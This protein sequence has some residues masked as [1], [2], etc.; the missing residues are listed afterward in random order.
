MYRGAAKGWGAGQKT[1]S[2]GGPRGWPRAPQAKRTGFQ[3]GEVGAGRDRGTVHRWPPSVW[4]PASSAASRL[5]SSAGSPATRAASASTNPPSAPT[6]LVGCPEAAGQAAESPAVTS[7]DSTSCVV[8]LP[9]LQ[10]GCQ[11]FESAIA[12]FA[13]HLIATGCVLWRLCRR[14]LEFC[15]AEPPTSDCRSTRAGKVTQ[16]K[17]R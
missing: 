8:V 9:R 7:C 3:R 12:N 5:R 2:P 15:A 6:R 1:R 16:P 10:R 14:C 17:P 13:S 11:P 4:S